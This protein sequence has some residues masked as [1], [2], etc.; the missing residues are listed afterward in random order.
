MLDFI[1]CPSCGYPIGAVYEAFNTIKVH[2]YKKELD[3]TTNIVINNVGVI[4]YIQLSMKD[5]FDQF[6]INNM[7]CRQHMI[8]SMDFSDAKYI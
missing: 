6:G 8:T 1:R 4:D 7:C 3:T 5:I 2:L